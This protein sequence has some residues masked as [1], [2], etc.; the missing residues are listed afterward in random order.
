MTR[1]DHLLVLDLDETLIHARE[2]PLDRAPDHA[3]GPYVVYRRPHLE[4]FLEAVFESFA[5]VGV[6]T[7][8]TLAYALPTLDRCRTSGRSRSGGGD[9]ACS[10]P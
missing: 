4:A 5:H 3:V 1:Y 10:T 7:A 8:S 2:D 9:V 6:W